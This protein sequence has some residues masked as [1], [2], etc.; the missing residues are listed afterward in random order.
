MH[1]NKTPIT[2]QSRWHHHLV[3][4]IKYCVYKQTF[5]KHVGMIMSREDTTT[6]LCITNIKQKLN[7][8]QTVGIGSFIEFDSVDRNHFFIIAGYSHDCCDSSRRTCAHVTLS[9][10][11]DNQHL[12]RSSCPFPFQTFPFLQKK[13]MTDMINTLKRQTE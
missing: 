1:D 11:E 8:L 7:I 10:F 4:H 9:M 3:Q 2:L 12:H 13:N 5:V 6:C